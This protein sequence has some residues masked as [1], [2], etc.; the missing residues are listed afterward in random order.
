M[1]RWNVGAKCEAHWR[2]EIEAR[3]SAKTH[4][5]YEDIDE[6]W[7]RIQA[8]PVRRRKAWLRSEEAEQAFADVEIARR[9]RLGLSDDEVIPDV[10]RITVSRPKKLRAQVIAQVSSAS[11]VSPRLTEA[12]WKEFR[13]LAKRLRS[14]V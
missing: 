1:E 4:K 13:Q 9:E 14:D 8:V 11:N 5:V 6:E 3:L 2:D 12:C 7:A 10:A